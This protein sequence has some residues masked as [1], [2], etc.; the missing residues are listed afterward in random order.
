[1][2]PEEAARILDAARRAARDAIADTTLEEEPLDYSTADTSHV[3]QQQQ[4]NTAINTTSTAPTTRP[5]KCSAVTADLFGANVPTTIKRL[6]M[7]RIPSPVTQN[8]NN[9]STTMENYFKT[10]MMQRQMDREER[11]VDERN[12]REEERVRREEERVRHEEETR[13]RKEETRQGKEE[14]RQGKEEQMIFNRYQE[15][16]NCQLQQM[17]QMLAI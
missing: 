2:V 12:R 16:Q 6:T 10:I 13:R 7:K 5:P 15:Q 1:V 14:T 8:D 4:T 17:M 9:I 3:V 11:V